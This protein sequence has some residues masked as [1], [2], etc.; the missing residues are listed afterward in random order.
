MMGRTMRDALH[1]RR[2]L[3]PLLAVSLGLCGCVR[4][5]APDAGPS[6]SASAG[7]VGATA[8]EADAS[9]PAHIEGGQPPDITERHTS[10]ATWVAAL[11][12]ARADQVLL[13]WPEIARLNAANAAKPGGFEDLL[14]PRAEDTGRVA[15]ELDERF[16]WLKG[17]V[18]SG[19]YVEQK[20]GAL[21]ESEVL[22]RAAGKVDELRMVVDEA[23]LRCVPTAS[24]FYTVPADEDF[25]RNQ[26]AS[27]RPTEIV[28][29]Q[30]RSEDGR[31]L[32]VHA[33]HSVGWLEE[34]RLTPPLTRA[35]VRHWRE[36]KP[37]LSVRVDR[38]ATDGGPTLRLGAS[39]PLLETGQV[40]VPTLEGLQ[41]AALP[42]GV[43]PEEGYLPFTRRQVFELALS[44]LD[45][46]YAWGGRGGG[47]DCSRYLL[48]LFAAF[49]V[50]LGRHSLAQAKAGTQ[51][52][53]V[54]GLSEADKRQKIREAAS[55]G[56]V[57]LYM[58]GHIMLYLGEDGDRQFA[59]SS[60]SEYLRP[61]ADD[62]DRHTTVHLDRVVVTDLEVGRGTERTAFI[63]RLTHLTVFGTDHGAPSP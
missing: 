63:E 22:A 9:C 62:K 57:L 43:K 38:L 20:K 10:L 28:R 2:T 11:G 48:D 35:Q 61:C 16:A 51:V 52:V 31:W 59:I 26:C 42:E 24:A 45:T 29:V 54:E 5:A 25:D 15:Q 41:P 36:M 13:R 34:P 32:Y 17:R 3:V 27:L 6:R 50:R 55:R 47:R 1:T 33:G 53:E 14:G 7:E 12:A 58:P 60:V 49:G 4:S 21:A 18:E 8:P 19:K 44:Q 23:D 39:V 30:R 40:L 56:V 46:P 37:R